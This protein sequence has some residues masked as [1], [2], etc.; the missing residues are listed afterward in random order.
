MR[1]GIDFDCTGLT[2][3]TLNL[4]V[5][6]QDGDATVFGEPILPLDL[7][8]GVVYDATTHSTTLRM[9]TSRNLPV[10]VYR[11]LIGPGISKGTLLSGP[12][13]WVLDTSGLPGSGAACFLNGLQVQ[14]GPGGGAV[15]DSGSLD[16]ARDPD[17]PEGFAVYYVASRKPYFTN[18]NAQGCA[19]A[20]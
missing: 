20:G 3:A 13:R 7:A 16:Q 19:N 5:D 4:P 8:R 6:S 18:P 15:T 17:P 1:C 2:T 12:P 10:D 9:W 14:A 11:G